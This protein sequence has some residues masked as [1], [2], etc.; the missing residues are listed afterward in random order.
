MLP[1]PLS[2]RIRRFRD[3]RGWSQAR[4]A[5]EMQD[6]G[7]TTLVQQR[8]DMIEHDRRVVRPEELVDLARV[9]NVPISELLGVPDFDP[10]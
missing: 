7:H 8:I 5:E 1:E 9:F 3:E 10:R 6:R 2:D 4:L